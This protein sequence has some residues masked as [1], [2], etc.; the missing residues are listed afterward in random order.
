MPW[1]QSNYWTV[2]TKNF[3]TSTKLANFQEIKKKDDVI[4]WR[5]KGLEKFLT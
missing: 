5:H 2:K 4:L 1:H 3:Q